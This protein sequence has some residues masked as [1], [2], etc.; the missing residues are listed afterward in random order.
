M[1]VQI[2]PWAS[3]PRG[4]TEA[5]RSLNPLAPVQIRAGLLSFLEDLPYNRAMA[6]DPRD[7]SPFGDEFQ[8]LQTKLGEIAP[9][10]SFEVTWDEDVYHVWDGDGPDPREEGYVPHN[11]DVTASAIVKGRAIEGVNYLGG[12]YDYPDEQDAGIHGYLPQ[13]MEEAVSE[14][15]EE[16]GFPAR[17]KKEARAA[18]GFLE[19]ELKRRYDRDMRRHQG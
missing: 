1:E 5:R 19:A 8:R 10:I 2:L 16:K 11:V 14:L 6:D 13:M 4:V 18:K 15:M 9:S 17:L 3:L 7:W 12:V